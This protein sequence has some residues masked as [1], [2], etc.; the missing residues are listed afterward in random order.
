MPSHT[1]LSRSPVLDFETRRRDERERAPD[2]RAPWRCTKATRARFAHKLAAVTARARGLAMRARQQLA[3]VVWALSSWRRPRVP[4]PPP[5][6]RAR[7]KRGIAR[8][9]PREASTESTALESARAL[10]KRR[11]RLRE[12]PSR[13]NVHSG[14]KT[15]PPPKVRIL[16]TLSGAASCTRAFAGSCSSSARFEPSRVKPALPLNQTISLYLSLSLS[17]SLVRSRAR[18]RAQVPHASASTQSGV[19]RSLDPVWEEDLELRLSGGAIDNG[20]W[21][22]RTVP[23]HVLLVQ[24]WDAHELQPDELLG[25]AR[26]PIHDIMHAAPARFD[27]LVLRDALNETNGATISIT[28]RL[29]A[30]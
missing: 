19:R 30:K 21:R 22:N 1:L 7:Q 2:T 13:T 28:L 20:R 23:F 29:S 8:H 5:H 17:L 12:A 16:Q 9:S 3:A 27:K 24:V 18:A 10:R 25:E 26:I 11:R 14:D 6:T 4:P 15:S